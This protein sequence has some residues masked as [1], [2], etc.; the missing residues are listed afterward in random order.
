MWFWSHWVLICISLITSNVEHLFMQ[1]LAICMSSFEKCLF[2]SSA[3]FWLSCLS[4]ILIFMSC[5]YMLDINPLSVTSANIFSHIIGCLFALFMVSFAAQKKLLSLI[6]SQLFIFAFVSF[7]LGDWS[8]KIELWFM[9]KY[10]LPIFSSTDFM[11]SLSYIYVFKPFSVY[12]VYVVREC[13]NFIDLHVTVQLSQH[14]LLKRLFFS[15]LC[16]LASFIID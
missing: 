15:P 11:V 2:R 9:S 3:H 8:K 14:Q 7:A 10:V 13:F 4:L 6:S 12:F 16:I 5:L 1:L